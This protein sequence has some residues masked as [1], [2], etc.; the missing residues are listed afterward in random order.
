MF[1]V[2]IPLPGNSMNRYFKSPILWLLMICLVGNSPAMGIEWPASRLNEKDIAWLQNH[3]ATH[4]QT[5]V[6]F[7]KLFV[8]AEKVVR[9]AAKPSV[10]SK[11]KVPPSGD[12]RDYYSVSRYW[13]P[14]PK[15]GDELPWIRKDGETNPV[16]KSA[17]YDG[18]RLRDVARWIESVCIVYAISEDEVYAKRATELLQVFFLDEK[19]G[20]R[21]NFRYSGSVP[22]VADGRASGLIELRSITRVLDV[23]HVLEKSDSFRGAISNGMVQW[24]RDLLDWILISSIGRKESLS[25]NNH[26]TY[27]D[28]TVMTLALVADRK[29]LAK[30]VATDSVPSRIE[31][32]FDDSGKQPHELKRT[33]SLHY[34][35]FNIL[36]YL[37]C[38]ELGEQIGVDIWHEKLERGI[39]YVADP[40]RG[41]QPWPHL[42]KKKVQ[43]RYVLEI[44]R[45]LKRTGR[46]DLAKGITKRFQSDEDYK[47]SVTHLLL[48]PTM[49]DADR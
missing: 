44:S 45:L 13:W 43:Y 20:M 25:A 31:M 10:T 15:T 18:E 48:P 5:K 26:G 8:D 42:Q 27:L 6:A 7:K 33:L 34:S 21:P 17:A 14:N 30:L 9:R 1:K 23:I 11:S 22:G 46:S 24:S 19:T 29:N 47:K 39:N 16:C 4:P 28:A 35:I 12:K 38:R 49:A 2:Q 36:A 40:L 3:G 37:K 41:D 32:Q